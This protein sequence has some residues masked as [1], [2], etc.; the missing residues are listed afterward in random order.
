MDPEPDLDPT[1]KPEPRKMTAVDP[2]LTLL[3][4]LAMRP[5]RTTSADT[6][7]VRVPNRIPDVSNAR[8]L[9]T[10]PQPQIP[11]TELSDAHTVDAHGVCP[12]LTVTE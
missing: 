11:E 12:I 10:T 3:P 8:E 1:P 4:P 9:L 7:V 5:T 6:P 2:V